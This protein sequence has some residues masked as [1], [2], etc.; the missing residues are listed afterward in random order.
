V[1]H[2]P[3]PPG[4]FGVDDQI[5]IDFDPLAARQYSITLADLT[6]DTN[7]IGGPHGGREAFILTGTPQRIVHSCAFWQHYF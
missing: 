2:C 1:L 5:T 7:G 6:E 3:L 4:R